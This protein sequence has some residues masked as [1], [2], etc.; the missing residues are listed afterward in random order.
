MKLE[1]LKACT[2]YEQA[3]IILLEQMYKEIKAV[4]QILQDEDTL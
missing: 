4:R 2:P 3:V 1:D